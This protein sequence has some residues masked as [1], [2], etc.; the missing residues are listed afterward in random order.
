MLKGL[1]PLDPSIVT[2]WYDTAGN[3]THY[4]WW[5]GY[6]ERVVFA[7][8]ELI[9]RR[10]VLWADPPPLYTALACRGRRFVHDRLHSGLFCQCRRA[11]G[12]AQG[13]GHVVESARR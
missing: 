11:L 3:L 5:P 6:G 13:Q 7:P 1:N 10:T 8:D 12:R 2:E 9:V 4:E